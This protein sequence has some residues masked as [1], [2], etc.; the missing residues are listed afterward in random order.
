MPPFLDALERLLL[1]RDGYYSP[2]PNRSRRAAMILAVDRGDSAASVARSAG[3]SR[4]TVKYWVRLYRHHRDPGA[5]SGG[6]SDKIGRRAI[7]MAAALNAMAGRAAKA[8][9]L[10]LDPEGRRRLRLDAEI[11]PDP[12]QRR[13]AA[14]LWA[15]ERGVPAPHVAH[16]AGISRQAVHQMRSKAAKDAGAPR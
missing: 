6:R 13:R 9:V 5:L 11:A 4:T 14:I 2:D 1:I 10:G 3:C 15:V 7:E 16:V 8:R 12:T